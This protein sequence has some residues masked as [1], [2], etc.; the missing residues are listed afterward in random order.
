MPYTNLAAMVSKTD[1]TPPPKCS[2][3]SKE[4]EDN[5]YRGTAEFGILGKSQ[6]RTVQI[7]QKS[8]LAFADES[9]RVVFQIFVDD[10]ITVSFPEDATAR[11]GINGPTIPT[12]RECVDP[13]DLKRGAYGATHRCEFWIRAQECLIEEAEKIT[14]ATQIVRFGDGYLSASDHG[15]WCGLFMA[16]PV[17]L[18]V[19]YRDA[20]MNVTLPGDDGDGIIL[21]PDVIVTPIS[22]PKLVTTRPIVDLT[23]GLPHHPRSLPA[24]RRRPSELLPTYFIPYFREPIPH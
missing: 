7:H 8:H 24:R 11:L 15:K 1:L 17:S 14:E 21:I 19:E 12:D 22:L 18:R 3:S 4:S 23:Q 16:K 5:P 6:I 9:G 10:S 13:K 2:S 20:W